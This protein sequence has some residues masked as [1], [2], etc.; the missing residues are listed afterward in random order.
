MENHLYKWKATF[1]TCVDC[2]NVEFVCAKTLGKA[3]DTLV[4]KHGRK[5]IDSY[6]LKVE[7]LTV[8]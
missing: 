2:C 1:A 8:L 6:L 5:F 3:L 7:F 4:V